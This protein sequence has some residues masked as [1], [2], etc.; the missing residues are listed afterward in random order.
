MTKLLYK[1]TTPNELK[2]SIY[3]VFK[4]DLT[5]CRQIIEGRYMI[6]RS[7]PNPHLDLWAPLFTWFTCSTKFFKLLSHFASWTISLIFSRLANAKLLHHASY[8]KCKMRLSYLQR[9]IEVSLSLYDE[10]IQ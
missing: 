2:N 3:Q 6:T 7:E 5:G 10:D 8:V 9:L 1:G 4:A